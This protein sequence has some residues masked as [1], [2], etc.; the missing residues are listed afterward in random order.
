M[1][2]Y[3]KKGI[4]LW[5]LSFLT[6]LAALNTLNAVMLGALQYT[7]SPI[8]IYVISDITQ[9]I[10][11]T[12]E[13]QAI[14]YFWVS[15]ALTFVFLGL[16]AIVATRKPPLDPALV[17]MFVKLDGNLTANRKTLK[18]GL[19]ENKNTLETVRMDMLEGLDG[20]KKASEKLLGTAR[21]EIMDGLE[22]QWKTIQSVREELRSAIDTNVSNVKQETLAAL[23]KQ[24]RAI[25]KVERLNKQSAETMEKQMAELIDMRT[26]LEKMEEFKPPQP[27]LTSLDKPEDVRGIG[28]RL[29]K[30]FKAIGITSVAELVTTDPAVIAEKTRVSQDMAKHLQATAQ[31]QMIPGVDENDAELLKEAEV[32]TIRELAE[33][34]PIQLSGKVREIAK[35]YVEE[36]KITEDEKPTVEEVLSW[37]KLAKS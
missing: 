11:G 35:T 34:D 30:E 33:Q 19:E 32:F 8:Q 1:S 27:K 10:V 22:E 36:G 28:P 25:Q 23:G 16:T 14:S 17:R 2:V 20:N 29:A 37:V 5:I 26:R 9:N 12:R 6:F 21:K 7:V 24:R 31:L 18:E 13:I 3:F 15:T 4:T